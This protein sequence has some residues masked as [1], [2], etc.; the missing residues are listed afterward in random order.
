MED[1]E[2]GATHREGGPLGRHPRLLV[3]LVGLLLLGSAAGCSEQ[4]EGPQPSVE[5]PST[6]QQPLPVAPGIVCADQLD[7]TV[8]LTGKD[9]SPLVIDALEKN[10]RIEYPTVKLTRTQSLTGEDQ[11]PQTVV[12][13]GDPDHPTNRDLLQWQSKKQMTFTVNQQLTLADGSTGTLPT[14]ILD[15]Q[16]TNAN[17]NKTVSQGALAVAPKP[18]LTALTPDVVCLA[19]GERTVNL[20]GT[21]FLEINGKSAKVK[22]EG[23]DT[24]L[25]ISLK[26]DSC[27]DIAHAGIDARTCT[28]AD[29]TLAKDQLAVGYPSLTVD[30]PETAACHSE[31]TV[32]LRVVPP[33]SIDKIVPPMACVAQEDRTFE[34]QGSD[35]LKIDGTTPTV[36]VAGTQFDVTMSDCEALETMSSDVQKCSTMTM[37]I[38]QGAVDPGVQDVVVTNPEPAGCSNQDSATVTIVP[39]PSIDEVQPPLVCVDDGPRNV[40]IVGTGFL[41]VDDGSGVQ[42]PSVEFDGTAVDAANVSP[43]SCT[44]VSVDGLTVQTCTELVVTVSQTELSGTP[45]FNPSVTVTNPDPAGCSDSQQDLLTV[46]SGPTITA[47]DPALV[48]TDDG[49]R[50]VVL[51]GTNFLTIDGTQPTVA[52]D[53]TAVDAASVASSDCTAQ[54]N[55]AGGLDVQNCTTLTLDLPQG[56]LSPGDTNVEVTNPDPAGCSV[57]NTDVLTVPPTLAITSVDPTNVCVSNTGQN[58]LTINGTGFLKVDGQWFSLNIGGTDIAVTDAMVSNCT[59]LTVAGQTV[60]SCQTIT[61][62]VDTSSFT[63]GPVDITITN[64]GQATC[65]A[66]I[67]DKFGIA[68][69]PTVTSIDPAEVCANTASTFTVTGS[70]FAQGAT[71]TA[72]ASDGTRID[73]D[74]VT[75]VSDTELQVTFSAGLAD[76]TYDIEVSN[77]QG[78]Q[79]TKQDLLVVN[80]IPVVFF[81]DPP[82]LYNGIATQVTI[83][84]SGLSAAPASI[85]LVDSNGNSTP[86][87]TYTA[88]EPNRIQATIPSGLPADNYQVNVTSQHGCTGGLPGAVEITDQTSV[89]ID[90]ITPPFGWKDTSTS[91]TITADSTAA[92]ANQFKAT[93]RVYLN[94][95]NASATTTATELHATTFNSATELSGIVPAGLNVGAYDVIVVNP[96]GTVGVL[97]GGFNVTLDA[98]PVIDSVSPGSL[99]KGSVTSVTLSGSGFRTDQTN[100]ANPVTMSCL[101]PGM[102]TPTTVSTGNLS[103]DFANSTDTQVIVS[104]DASG[105]TAN[106]ACVLRFTNPD[107]TYGEYGPVVITNPSSAQNFLAFQNAPTLNTARR[108][109]AVSSGQPSR[110][111]RFVY[112][113][114][115]DDGSDANALRTVEF[116]RIDRFGSPVG[117]NM[118]QALDTTSGAHATDVLPAGGRGLSRAVRIKD[119]I[120]L[121]A[122]Y[123][124]TGASSEGAAG[125]ILRANVLD[126][127]NVPEISDVSFAID[128]GTGLGKGVYYYRVSAVLDTNSAYNPGGETLAS[129]PLPVSVPA[130]IDGGLVPTITWNAFPGATSYRIYRSP[131]ADMAYGNEQLIATVNDDGS[132]SY[133]LTDANKAPTNSDHPL[134]VGA[135][136]AWHPLTQSDGTPVTLTARYMHGATRLEDP[137]SAGDYFIY[138]AGGLDTGGNALDSVDMVTIHVNGKRDQ[139]VAA[140]QTGAATLSTPRYALQITAATQNNAAVLGSSPLLYAFTGETTTGNGLTTATEY[141]PIGADG[142]LGSTTTVSRGPSNAYSGYAGG[143]ANGIA[144]MSGGFHAGPSDKATK[145]LLQSNGDFSTW[146][147]LSGTGMN[148]LYLMGSDPFVGFLYVAG[149][150]QLDANNNLVTVDS[151]Q[152]SVVGTA[153]P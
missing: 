5:N 106:S 123:D 122:G 111:Q 150:E 149:G 7:T 16:V 47:A 66:T 80:P 145:G 72:I 152:F 2:S 139:T 13:S 43:Q 75:R 148:P 63:E 27:K 53:G 113:I 89:A 73:A 37:V 57:S 132:G 95:V 14:G 115:G 8:T 143:I 40:T 22:A 108:Q 64:A 42:V 112:V 102:T 46:M 120:Y 4:I 92:A 60:Q 83:F 84:T 146:S 70:D 128:P 36:T 141:M 33:P 126:P 19:E 142:A 54:A 129:E 121:V 62:E 109:P 88:T 135:L 119:F 105:L 136:G 12:Y 86:I 59:D 124:G 56:S 77:G 1:Y 29:L 41:T 153:T 20:T 81:V 127:L 50:Q 90:A 34:I 67:S 134:P 58:T 69:P 107:S 55:V 114:G 74:T 138:A 23:V 117:F 9:F 93:P 97:P 25:D 118:M 44:D 151:V 130:A 110:E 6:D 147:A 52:L 76:G 31:E 51:T 38:P 137:Q 140:V 144:F 15:V 99:E 125:T 98:P 48:C 85:E 65:G 96:D 24:P 3:M 32:N 103:V 39:P 116:S 78:C 49:A 104:V 17:D 91:V 131:S 68:P 26:D 87:T 18:Q 100:M 28:S 10:S 45:P 21:T 61:A 30:N 82:V 94:P 35:F 11:E 133:S 79:S 101:A 71:L